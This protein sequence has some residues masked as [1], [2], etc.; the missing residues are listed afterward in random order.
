MLKQPGNQSRQRQN[1]GG[2]TCQQH[3]QK[4]RMHQ[5]PGFTHPPLQQKKQPGGHFCQ[6]IEQLSVNAGNKGNGAARHPGYHISS[7]HCHAL[8]IQQKIFIH[9]R[10]P[11]S[12]GT[13]R[14]GSSSLRMKFCP[15]FSIRY[16]RCSS[17]SPPTG[18]TRRPP[19]ASCSSTASST[20]LAAAVTKIPL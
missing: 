18:I 7:T 3:Q 10:A 14:T 6:R 1:A 19:G 5:A 20:S 13:K 17:C 16:K 8:E 11:L 15:V 4:I 2:N 12:R 9:C